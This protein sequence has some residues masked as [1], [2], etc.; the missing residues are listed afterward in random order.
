M[1]N[2]IFASAIGRRIAPVLVAASALCG[3]LGLSSVASA[4]EEIIVTAP[5]VEK[6]IVEQPRPV[7]EKVIVE[8]VAAPRPVIV[9]KVVARPEIIV[10]RPREEII[11]G[12]P[13]FAPVFYGPACAPRFHARVVI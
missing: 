8:R 7:V 3:T 11:V 1:S 13:R 12:R 5:V 10:A 2:Y 9:E 4:S 6:V